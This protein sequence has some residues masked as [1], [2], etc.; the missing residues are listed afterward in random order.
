MS[1]ET[2][3]YGATESLITGGAWTT[4]EGY[5][6]HYRNNNQSLQGLAQLAMLLFEPLFVVLLNSIH[7]LARDEKRP[8]RRI[9]VCFGV[10]FATL[11][12]INYF[13][14]LTGQYG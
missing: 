12:S 13:V 8:L 14:Q 6:E 4:L 1:M 2:P 3:F 9:G 7:N 10:A 5:L 11:S